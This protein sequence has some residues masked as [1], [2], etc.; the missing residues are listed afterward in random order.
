MGDNAGNGIG[1][2]VEV[3]KRLNL[4]TDVGGDTAGYVKFFTLLGREISDF[5]KYVDEFLAHEP[6]AT[7]QT[8]YRGFD[9][10]PAKTMR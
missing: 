10:L 8:D 9:L 5:L 7:K 1:A 3:K 4:V 2:F 6:S